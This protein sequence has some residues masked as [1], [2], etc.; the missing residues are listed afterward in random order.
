M[1]TGDMNEDNI[2]NI[3]DAIKAMKLTR[4]LTSALQAYIAQQL[5]VDFD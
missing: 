1:N 3:N 5:A 2:L 4:E